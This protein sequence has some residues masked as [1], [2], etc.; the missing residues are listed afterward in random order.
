ME[1]NGTAGRPADFD[2]G[3]YDLSPLPPEGMSRRK[4]VAI[5]V[6][7]VVL[8]I[9]A[10]LVAGVVIDRLVFKEKEAESF[11]LASSPAY[12][13]ALFNIRNYY[14]R[15]FSEE[16]ITAAAEKAVK[17][18]QDKG[19]TDPDKLLNT[20]L[21]A[22]IKALDDQHSG[23]LTPNANKRLSEDLSG[24]FYGVGFTLRLDEKLDRPKVV[25]VIKGSPAD[26]AG[27][28][29]G[30]VIMAVDGEDT[31]GEALD[32]VVLRIRGQKGTKVKLD[33]ERK[34]KPMEFEITREKIDIPDFESEMI[35]GDIGVLRLFE[36]N[37]GV[38]EKVRSGVRDLQ[39]K[40]AK[41]FILDLRNN[42]GGLLDEAVNVTSVFVPEGSPVVSYRTKGEK[43]VTEYAK[44]GQE[45]DLPLVVLTNG[46]SASSS[47]IT[48]G[49]LRDLDRAVLVGSKTYGKG[50]VQKVYELENGGAAK[51]TVALYFL[52]N[53]DSV[54]NAGLEPRIKVAEIKDDQEKTEQMQLDK[55]KEVLSNLVE[56][57]PPTG[58]VFLLAA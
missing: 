41:G 42:P 37:D 16:K 26:R 39:Q 3:S 34:G 29:S 43:K 23:Y 52:P 11:E 36:F 46:G 2:G 31:K 24:S 56:G 13:D 5:G 8:L 38:G 51:L 53:G 48:A 20:G 9:A 27:I 10:L 47:E 44:G 7:I 1:E 33:V 55:A 14:Y 22:L 30:D 58:E 15:S 57:K 49:A 19:V 12:K 35:D 32:S 25:T 45:T 54:D 28:K 40:G 17:E 50:S 18:K 4:K 6:S 21:T